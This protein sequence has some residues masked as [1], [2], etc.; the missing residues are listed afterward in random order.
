MSPPVTYLFIR[1]EPELL[2]ELRAVAARA[3]V[4]DRKR[5]SPRRTTQSSICREALAIGLAALAKAY[6]AAPA[7][8]AKT[9]SRR[10]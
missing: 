6:P 8:R 9:G 10:G 3:K 7:A 2:A 5:D 4:R 1:L